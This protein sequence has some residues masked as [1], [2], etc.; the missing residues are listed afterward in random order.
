MNILPLNH[1]SGRT[2]EF[3]YLTNTQ[4]TECDIAE[5]FEVG[6]ISNERISA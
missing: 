1:T 5:A 2:A 3:E 4:K 6:I